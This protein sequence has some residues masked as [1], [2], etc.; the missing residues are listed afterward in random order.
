MFS[1]KK[2]HL[3]LHSVILRTAKALR[4]GG[5]NSTLVFTDSTEIPEKKLERMGERLLRRE[6]ASFLFLSLSALILP[7]QRLGGKERKEKRK[8]RIDSQFPDTGVHY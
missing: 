8:K 4:Q 1:R 2:E 7:I 5:E 6:G 3:K